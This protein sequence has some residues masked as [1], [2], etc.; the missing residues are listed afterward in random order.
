[1]SESFSLHCRC[2]GCEGKAIADVVV[3]WVDEMTQFVKCLA[4]DQLVSV[5]QQG[6]YG[7]M[8]PERITTNPSLSTYCLGTDFIR[9]SSLPAVD[10]ATIQVGLGAA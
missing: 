10:Y 8:P 4:P 7:P 1:M 3:S 9:L 5:A 6:F 2:P